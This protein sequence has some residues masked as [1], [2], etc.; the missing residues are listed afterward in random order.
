MADD[1]RVFRERQFRQYKSDVKKRGKPFHAY[2]MLHDTIMSL[3]TVGVII[4]LAV[5]WKW[6]TPGDHTGIVM[7]DG[8]ASTEGTSGWLGKLTDDPADPGTISFTP[9]PDWYFYFLF[10]LLRIFKWPESV[11][12]GTIGIPTICVLLLIALP[13]LDTRAERRPLR[14]PVAMVTGVLVI[15]S[16]GIMTYRGATANESLGSELIGKVP[17]WAKQQGFANN[18]KAVAGAKLFA[19]AGCMNCHVYLGNGASNLGG[20]ELTA[21]GAQHRGIL[22]QVEHLKCPSCVTKGSAMPAFASQGQANL[23][24]MAEFLEASQGPK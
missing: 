2:A 1:R 6:T 18:P 9:R 16:M 23:T 4:A 11:I 5:V 21:E 24:L 10:Y 17:E 13:F 14:R 8:V 7:H 22:F 20:P 15:F 3:V 12:L 19:V